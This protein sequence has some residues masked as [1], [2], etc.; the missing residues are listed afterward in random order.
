MK[1]KKIKKISGKII[2]KTGLH[3]GTSNDNLE[4]GGIDNPVIKNPLTNEPYIPGSSL[5]GKIRYLLE[6]KYNKFI[7]NSEKGE[8]CN[9]GE[10]NCF[11]CNIFGTSNSS[12]RKSG[13]TRVIFRDAFLNKE[14][15]QKQ[16]LDSFIEEKYEN[17]IDRITAK[18]NPRSM[19]RVIPETVFDFEIVYKIYDLNND[20]GKTDEDNFKYLLEGLK[21]L[22]LDYLGG[23]GSR[24]NG[25]IEFKDL[26]D[27][28]NN[29]LSLPDI[30]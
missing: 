13:P 30:K 5:K 6:W 11:I 25:K 18:A 17:T 7:I 20:N 23:G 26:I 19:E 28:N 1:L 2:V 24:G 4:I 12:S 15:A 8:P 21:L 3:I 10:S 27:E 14:F 29:P 16:G 22:E 9:C